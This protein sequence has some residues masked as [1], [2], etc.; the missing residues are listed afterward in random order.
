MAS[1][2]G[3][4]YLLWGLLASAGLVLA[5]VVLARERRRF[6]QRQRAGAWLWLR[7]CTLPIVALCALAVLGPARLTRG[8]EALAVFYLLGLTLAPLLY[9]ALH[10]LLG[11][12]ARPPL[13]R[14]ESTQ[15]ALSGLLLIIVPLLAAQLAQAPVI[16]LAALIHEARIDAAPAAPVPHRLVEQRRFAMPTGGT[17]RYEHWQVPPGVR[18]ARVEQRIDGVFVRADDTGSTTLC[19]LGDDIH[20]FWPA[21]LPLPVWRIQWLDE[22]DVQ[23]RA[24]FSPARTDVLPEPFNVLWQTEGVRMPV[25][26]PRSIVSL[27]QGAQG[28]REQFDSVAPDSLAAAEQCLPR[29]YRPSVR[30]GKGPL[31]ALALRFWN[32]HRQQAEF[33]RWY[34]HDPG[35][36]QPGSEGFAAQQ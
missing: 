15:I 32:R 25:P 30:A 11:W 28:T 10:L 14:A 27:D 4:V 5:G 16:R 24:E 17:M 2:P 13:T 1:E 9:F 26:V 6:A 18:T 20:L 12:L 7:L 22:G 3:T 31:R 29:D 34:R 33:S 35:S 19:R 36:P 21:D 23:H 8:P